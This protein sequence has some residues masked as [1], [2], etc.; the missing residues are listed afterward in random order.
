MK[1]ILAF[2]KNT[3]E[4]IQNTHPALQILAFSV[5]AGILLLIFVFMLFRPAARRSVFYFTE[6]ATG[7]TRME[8]RYLPAVRDTDARLTLYSGEL[9]L[10]PVN[11]RY[12]PLFGRNVRVLRCFIR[13]HVAYID[14]STEALQAGNGK[15][16]SAKEAALLKKNVF[17]N[18]GNVDKMYLYIDGL[19]V[20][21]EIPEVGVD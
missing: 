18:F 6:T 15:F 14:L 16:F 20:Y 10:G 21:S 7:K 12:T 2:L 17:T 1:K 11:T 9:A 19:E 13:D 3:G 5:C 8:V 4:K